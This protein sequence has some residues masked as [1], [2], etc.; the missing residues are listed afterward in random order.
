MKARLQE[1]LG[2]Q[3]AEEAKSEQVRPTEAVEDKPLPHG[4]G[5]GIAVVR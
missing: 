5:V 2:K 1:K 4:S 3:E